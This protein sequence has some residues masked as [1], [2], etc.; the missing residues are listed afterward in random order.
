MQVLRRS[1][2]R[3]EDVRIVGSLASLIAAA[4]LIVAAAVYLGSVR[5]DA[6]Q[7]AN[8][9]R[10]VTHS[11]NS[12]QRALTTTVRDYAWWSEAVR[13]LVP[14]PNK[15]WADINIGPYVNATFG[16]EIALVLDGDDRPILGWLRDFASD[17]GSSSRS[18]RHAALTARRGA[19]TAIGLRADRCQRYPARRGGFWLRPPVRSCRSRVS[20]CCCHPGQL[21]CWCL[22]SGSTMISWTGCA[23]TSG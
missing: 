21:P 13:S 17:G 12:L 15:D 14:T 7:H 8:E 6:L 20:R 1:L 11:V 5:Q 4:L 18:G 22:P 2:R 10:L 16:Y 3:P 23:R 19:A 9:E